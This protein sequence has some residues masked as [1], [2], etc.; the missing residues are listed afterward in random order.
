M[1][2]T[3]KKGLN[4]PFLLK[5]HSRQSSRVQTGKKTECGNFLQINRIKKKLKCLLQC[6]F[7]HGRHSV[8][9]N[10]LLLAGSLSG[11]MAL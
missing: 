1:S 9:E 3:P 10:V 2:D 6:F 4:A 8:E 7:A 11:S 5:E